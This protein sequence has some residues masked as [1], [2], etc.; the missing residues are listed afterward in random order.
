MC[1]ELQ[2]QTD[3]AVEGLLTLTG[4]GGTRVECQKCHKRNLE[5]LGMGGWWGGSVAFSENAFL[6]VAW[7]RN[8]F[9]RLCLLGS[10][11]LS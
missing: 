7:L 9:V 8:L 4:R 10:Y 2:S 6:E 5:P 11:W 3:E 1:W